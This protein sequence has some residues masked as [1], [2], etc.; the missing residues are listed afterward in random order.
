MT[1]SRARPS[2]APSPVPVARYDIERARMRRM[3]PA[4]A[5]SPARRRAAA[6]LLLAGLPAAGLPPARR[7]RIRNH[8]SRA[9]PAG[10]AAGPATRLSALSDAPRQRA[11]Q[12]DGR[13]RP[14]P[15]ASPP[16]P[17]GASTS[18]GSGCP[19]RT[20][21][22]RAGAARARGSG[23]RA[24]Q[25]TR[26]PPGWR[27]PERYWQAR[28]SGWGV[29]HS[30]AG[31]AVL[32]VVAAGVP[33]PGG[34]CV[35]VLAAGGGVVESEGVGDDGG[36]DLEDELA[37]GGDA[38]GAQGQ[39]EGAELVGHGVVGGGLAGLAAGE[40]PS[41][42]GVGGDVVVAGGGELVQQRVEGGGDG[43]WRV[44]EPEPGLAVLVAG[45]IADRQPQD[46][47]E[48]L[49]VEQQQARGGARPDRGGGGSGEAAQQVE[50]ALLGDGRAG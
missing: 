1:P 8:G 5:P 6:C 27:P 50:P 39:A 24:R 32:G 47:G 46:A 19:A 26:Y 35:D 18:P 7:P 49:G 36:G 48:R 13:H 38:G 14:A 2:L 4:A 22:A 37:Q 3:R 17:A 15:L 11:W 42:G 25:E 45:E 34:S 31:L 29:F 44:A 41:A 33:A 10:P 21:R 40:Q 12:E 28:V 23:E 43:A 20:R 16:R 30:R 9:P